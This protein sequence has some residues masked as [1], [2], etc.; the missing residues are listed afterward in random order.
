MDFALPITCNDLE[1][2]LVIVFYFDRQP[3]LHFV[4]QNP[5][6]FLSAD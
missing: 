3:L 2:P 4:Q 6:R 5:V 1:D